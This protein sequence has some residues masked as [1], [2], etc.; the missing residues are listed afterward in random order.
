[1]YA[2][3][4]NRLRDKVRG[5]VIEHIDK[6][7]ADRLCKQISVTVSYRLWNKLSYEVNL[8]RCQL[9]YKWK[10]QVSTYVKNLALDYL[11]YGQ[12]DAN[13]LAYYSYIM[14]VLRAEAPKV[15]IQ[16]VLLSKEVNWWFPTKE[17]VFITRKPKECIVKD[18]EFVKLVY[19]DGYAII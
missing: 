8:I 15:L 19:Q 6:M 18:G 13:W 16:H 5:K 1:M 2:Q 9:S 7:L 11:W 4:V 10:N 14:Q 3:I 12:H 17:V